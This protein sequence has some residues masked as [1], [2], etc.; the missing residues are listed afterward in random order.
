M[1]LAKI[2]SWPKFL[3]L[4]YVK[5]AQQNFQQYNM[6]T[7]NYSYRFQD[8]PQA[9]ICLSQLAEIHHYKSQ[10]QVLS[11]FLVPLHGHKF[12]ISSFDVI[13][14]ESYLVTIIMANV[15]Y[16]CVLISLYLQACHA[17]LPK[18]AHITCDTG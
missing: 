5:V 14:K 7:P 9:P 15:S 13:V 1:K 6:H 11:T 4:Q 8:L 18:K 17:A 2:F 16:M 10:D 3:A 12:Q